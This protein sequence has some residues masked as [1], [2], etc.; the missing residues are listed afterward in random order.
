MV[1]TTE[2]DLVRML[3]L[4]PLPMPVAWVPL[5]VSVEPAGEFG[6]WLAG[7]LAVRRGGGE[8]G[9]R[10]AALAITVKGLSH[11]EPRNLYAPRTHARHSQVPTG[12]RSRS[13]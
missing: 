13:L 9:R 3:P 12:P 2:K 8:A 7:R 5:R 6:D 1:L 10:S 4:R 11:L